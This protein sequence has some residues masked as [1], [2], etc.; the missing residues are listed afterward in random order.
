MIDHPDEDAINM[1][2][3]L[4]PHRGQTI[5]RMMEEKTVLAIQ[6]GS[7]LNYSGLNDCEG[8]GVIGSNQ[9]G[10][11]S[12]GLHLHSTLVVTTE[13]LPLGILRATCEARKPDMAVSCQE[14][15]VPR[16][17]GFEG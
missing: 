6:D 17:S 10:A 9:T 15:K 11:E 13:G 4:S 3:V 12:N 16:P 14:K 2:T 1:D 5:R 8:L 7:D